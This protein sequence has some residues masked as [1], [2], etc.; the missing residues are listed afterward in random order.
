MFCSPVPPVVG[1]PCILVEYLLVEEKGKKMGRRVLG[2]SLLKRG[3]ERRCRT[4][5]QRKGMTHLG[6][7]GLV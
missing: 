6:Q 5:A 4:R 7:C 1:V 2:A 3:P